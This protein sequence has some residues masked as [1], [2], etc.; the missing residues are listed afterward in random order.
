MSKPE[1]I[2]KLNLNELGGFV[3]KEAEHYCR[4]NAFGCEILCP[5]Y[6]NRPV[7]YLT[8]LMRKVGISED[9]VSMFYSLF[10]E[11]N[12]PYGWFQG[13]G[14]PEQIES[15]IKYFLPNAGFGRPKVT[16][17]GIRDLMRLR[18]IGVDCSGFVFNI[19]NSG[20]RKV[21]FEKEFLNSLK[22]KDVA[23]QNVFQAGV[24][25]LAESSFEVAQENL[26]ALDLLVLEKRGH[27]AIVL[28][29]IEG[30][31]KVFQSTPWVSPSG[32]NVSNLS[33]NNG[34]AN[35]SFI[36]SMGDNWND[37]NSR[38]EV[39]FRRLDIFKR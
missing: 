20:F 11:N 21:G 6:I 15:A 8:D 37:M 28:E 23:K 22:W 3:L 32:I 16:P 24:S 18:G 10:K 26:R 25:V 31:L 27:I 34:I 33:I 1:R 4:L 2:E 29:D 38:G 9:E 13:K 17:E 39:E 36:P 19:L 5:Y 7:S 14:T 12:A 35:F 30:K